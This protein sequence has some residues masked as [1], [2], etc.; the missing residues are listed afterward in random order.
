MSVREAAEKLKVTEKTVYQYISDGKLT[1]EK[2]GHAVILYRSQV[3]ALA[4]ARRVAKHGV[5][6]ELAEVA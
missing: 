4:N 1:S 2:V 3:E 5:A 6:S